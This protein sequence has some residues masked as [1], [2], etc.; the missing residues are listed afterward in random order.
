GMD[1]DT[2]VHIF[3]KFYQGD[4]S[5]SLKGYGLG[6]AITKRI[7]ELSNGEIIVESS[8]GEGSTFYIKLFRE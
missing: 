1:E 8:I 2:L 5:R 3:D 6:L 7:V 4:N